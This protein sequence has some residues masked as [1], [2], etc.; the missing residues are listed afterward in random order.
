VLTF[1]EWL[2]DF[3]SPGTRAVGIKV[4]EAELAEVSVKNPQAF[5]RLMESYNR[6]V[7]GERDL[8]F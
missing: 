7:A 8:F 5:P 1:R 2:D 6:I 4:L 3:A